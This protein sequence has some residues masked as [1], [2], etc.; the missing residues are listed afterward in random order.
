MAKR[1]WR[2]GE[3]GTGFWETPFKKEEAVVVVPDYDL[4]PFDELD[5]Q[6]N[7]PKWPRVPGRGTPPPFPHE[8]DP[9]LPPE[10]APEPLYPEDESVPSWLKP[11]P[12]FP[13]PAVPEFTT[14]ENL[15]PPGGTG[16]ELPDFGEKMPEFNPV[17][18]DVGDL[19]EA[20]T[21]VLPW[22][23]MFGKSAETVTPAL[24]GI[25]SLLPLIVIAMIAKD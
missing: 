18:P 5:D 21:P 8:L 20:I 16:F 11:L 6:G 24:V 7:A 22:A 13:A 1:I 15:V 12:V 3:G 4:D 10:G 2:Q 23:G 17:I 9:W 14:P 19:G 25:T